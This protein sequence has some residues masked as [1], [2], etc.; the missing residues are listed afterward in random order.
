MPVMRGTSAEASSDPD[1]PFGA[2]SAVL[3]APRAG[4]GLQWPGRSRSLLLWEGGSE[5]SGLCLWWKICIFY[6]FLVCNCSL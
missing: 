6:I 4:A 3:R 1:C 5:M 2:W